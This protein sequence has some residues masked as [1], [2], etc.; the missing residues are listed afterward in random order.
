MKFKTY[1]KKD[2]FPNMIFT[3][4]RTKTSLYE[5]LHDLDRLKTKCKGSI[6]CAI[7]LSLLGG[8]YVDNGECNIIIINY[9]TVSL[10][11]PQ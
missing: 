1:E 2:L 9:N 10:L 3:A 11:L 7:V 4:I 8:K 5:Y 6:P